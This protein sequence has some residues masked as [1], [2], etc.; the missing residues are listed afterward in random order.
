MPELFNAARWLV[1]RQVAE[2]NGGRTA[3]VTPTRSLT[4]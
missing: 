2:G 3:V 4:Y 1:D